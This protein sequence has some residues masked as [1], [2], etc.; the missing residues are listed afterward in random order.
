MKDLIIGIVL[1]AALMLWLRP[2]AKAE[3]SIE[4]DCGRTG[5][6]GMIVTEYRP[7]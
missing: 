7:L 4:T 1:G 3:P 5:D 6:Q 2:D